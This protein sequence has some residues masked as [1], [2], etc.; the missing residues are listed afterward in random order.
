MGWAQ[1]NQNDV[2]LKWELSEENPCC[3]WGGGRGG[4]GGALEQ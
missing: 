1:T 4:A 2:S 3:A